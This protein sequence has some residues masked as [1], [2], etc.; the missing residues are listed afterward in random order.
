MFSYQAFLEIQNCESE[1]AGLYKVIVRNKVGEVSAG[2]SL[3]IAERTLSSF[4]EDNSVLAKV[5]NITN[6]SVEANKKLQL[7]TTKPAHSVKSLSTEENIT[8]RQPYSPRQPYTPR[9]PYSSRRYSERRPNRS[10]ENVAELAAT[11]QP[12]NASVSCNALHDTSSKD[13]R[14]HSL[15]NVE[16]ACEVD[17]ISLLL[18]EKELCQDK[19]PS[20]F[21]S[22]GVAAL[23]SNQ[24]ST[25]DRFV[26]TKMTSK[27]RI[28]EQIP[29]TKIDTV[30]KNNLRPFSVETLEKSDTDKPS[31][32]KLSKI[33]PTITAIS[34]NNVSICLGEQIS[35]T[36]SVKGF[37]KPKII[38]MKSAKNLNDDDGYKLEESHD[39]CE[40]LNTTI[41]SLTV[42]AASSYHQGKY[43]IFAFSINGDC[44]LDFNVHLESNSGT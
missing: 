31:P 39:D 15:P 25:V 35:L 8:P 6:P 1:D 36:C 32:R 42:K 28:N 9:Q 34:S 19:N 2:A 26:N 37:P 22:D 7:P 38:W 33:P 5:K 24:E 20:V 23:D 43:T 14:L 29:P 44:S 21:E 11:K 17:E 12:R 27:K 18:P 13:L 40:G 16:S 10:V 30:E 4:A 3:L 41:A